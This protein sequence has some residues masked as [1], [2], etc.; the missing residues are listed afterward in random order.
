[1]PRDQSVEVVGIESNCAADVNSGQ[2]AAC[3]ET[4]HGAS[5]NT[6]TGCNLLDREQ[7]AVGRSVR[8]AVIA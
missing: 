8:S 3:D 5:M 6:E 7:G 4:L 1:V 2:L